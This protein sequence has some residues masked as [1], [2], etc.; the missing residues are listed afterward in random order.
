MSRR[1]PRYRH[2]SQ[3]M[4]PKPASYSVLVVDVQ[5]AGQAR[6]TVPTPVKSDS[7]PSH[8]PFTPPC[9]HS[10]KASPIEVF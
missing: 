4:A 5:G 6:Y 10:D 2:R 7:A 9:P 1:R 3:A 8:N